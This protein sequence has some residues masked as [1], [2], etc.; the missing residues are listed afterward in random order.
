MTGFGSILYHPW[1][2]FV[3]S[4]HFEVGEKALQ[5]GNS[6]TPTPQTS[7]T[8]NTF[9]TLLIFPSNTLETSFKQSLKFIDMSMKH[10]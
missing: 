10:L 6:L 7:E 2:V 9:E 3:I 1:E 8:L 5:S 4:P